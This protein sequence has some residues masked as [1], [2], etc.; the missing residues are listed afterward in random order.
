M[1][2]FQPK[3]DTAC[4]YG[5]AWGSILNSAWVIRLFVPVEFLE[6]SD[7]KTCKNSRN[8]VFLRTFQNCP[9]RMFLFAKIVHSVQRTLDSDSW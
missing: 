6:Y 1:G 7:A 5:V 4:K 8:N 9:N 3:T 2:N